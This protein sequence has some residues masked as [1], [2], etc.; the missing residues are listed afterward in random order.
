MVYVEGTS[1]GAKKAGLGSAGL[2]W[3]ISVDSGTQAV[4]HW[5]ASALG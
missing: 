2:V 3:I 5:P 4:L 1:N